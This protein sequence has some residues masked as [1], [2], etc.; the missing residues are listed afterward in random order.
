MKGDLHKD[1]NGKFVRE[2]DLPVEELV[3]LAHRTRTQAGLATTTVYF[4]F[5]CGECGERC[6]FQEPNRYFEFGECAACGA[7][8]P[9]NKGGI[10]VHFNMKP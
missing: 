3:E 6:T 10:T 9:F 8:T 7:T 5:T 1:E 2:G 4:K